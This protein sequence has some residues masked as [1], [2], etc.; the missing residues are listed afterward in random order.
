MDLGR[1]ASTY[2]RAEDL[3]TDFRGRRAGFVKALTTDFT[4]FYQQCD[5]AFK[6]DALRDRALRF[7]SSELR[8]LEE[9]DD[10]RDG[11]GRWR[12]GERSVWCVGLQIL[13]MSSSTSA[14]D[15][16]ITGELLPEPPGSR[17]C[18]FS[19]VLR[20]RK[21]QSTVTSAMSCCSRS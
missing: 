8:P 9:I 19:P 12:R 20:I 16:A 5:P 21:R 17:C 4:K 14:Q 11:G 6:T 15:A 3:F 2:R 10:Q 13:M 1:R 7:A 18:E